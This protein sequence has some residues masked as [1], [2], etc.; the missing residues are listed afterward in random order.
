MAT[1]YKCDQCRK[2]IK[3]KKGGVDIR[4]SFNSAL[5]E[6]YKLPS[7]LDICEDCAE[8][9]AQYL[10]RLMAAKPAK[11]PAKKL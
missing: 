6:K 9:L 4:F 1:I 5:P 10:K 3:S 11:K 2:N 8:P 7:S